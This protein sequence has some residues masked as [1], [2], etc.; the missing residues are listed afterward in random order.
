M[1]KRIFD[2]APPRSEYPD[3]ELKAV[4]NARLTADQK[5]CVHALLSVRDY[6][7]QGGKL[8]GKEITEA[9]VADIIEHVRYNA[10]IS[11]IDVVT[12]V[13]VPENSALIIGSPRPG[14]APGDPEAWKGRAAVI[15]NLE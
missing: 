9:T 7:K 14:V 3:P 15:R 11:R 10:G 13:A 1:S 12:S 2:M 5:F 8:N 6:L 4:K